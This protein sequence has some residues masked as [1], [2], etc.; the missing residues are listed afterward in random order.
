M[1]KASKSAA[2][3]R[4]GVSH[5]HGQIVRFGIFDEP[6]KYFLTIGKPQTCSKLR[7]SLKEFL[8]RLCLP[9]SKLGRSAAETKT[10]SGHLWIC[11]D[12]LGSTAL[13]NKS[14]IF[15]E[16]LGEARAPGLPGG[17]GKPEPAGNQRFLQEAS[18]SC[19]IRASSVSL[20]L[21][22]G[23]TWKNNA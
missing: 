1:S 21:G 2:L 19:R 15:L 9:C 4:I 7:S 14:L 20:P 18:V 11:T 8:N 22:N 17:R 16:M 5:S 23:S 12:A 13:C 10:E 3:L 6:E